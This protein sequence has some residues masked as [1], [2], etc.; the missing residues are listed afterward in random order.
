M[1]WLSWGFFVEC[2]DFREE[3][4]ARTSFLEKACSWL[5]ILLAPIPAQLWRP[6]MGN[7]SVLL[8]LLILPVDWRGNDPENALQSHHLTTFVILFTNYTFCTNIGI[9]ISQRPIETFVSI[10]FV[11]L[12]LNRWKIKAMIVSVS[13]TAPHYT[14][15]KD[16]TNNVCYCRLI[17]KKLLW[18]KRLDLVQKVDTILKMDRVCGR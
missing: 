12:G 3:S 8:S 1:G 9:E 2:C 6:T 13:C 16:Q 7:R 10:S 5:R 14:L 17:K 4:D 11:W 18:N 15:V